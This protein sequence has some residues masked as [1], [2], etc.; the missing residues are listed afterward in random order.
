MI[1]KRQPTGHTGP[2]A[3]DGVAASSLPDLFRRVCFPTA[4]VN[5]AAMATEAGLFL[6]GVL[7]Y[8]VLASHAA[9][10]RM[11]SGVARP[12]AQGTYPGPG[13][14]FLAV[15]PRLRAHP[16]L[17]PWDP[18]EGAWAL[19][20]RLPSWRLCKDGVWHVVGSCDGTLHGVG[21]TTGSVLKE[22]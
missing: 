20:L 7:S 9:K 11:L 5:V 12:L 18:C 8:D 13:P 6:R 19:P 21:G 10:S 2:G 4:D 14:G 17:V 15:L 22:D 1:G 16:E 3:S